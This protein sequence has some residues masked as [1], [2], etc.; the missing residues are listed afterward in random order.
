VTGLRET[1]RAWIVMILIIL[2]WGYAWIAAKIALRYA[3]ALDAA[4]VRLVFGTLFLFAFL[5]WSKASLRP[6]H[7]KW[8]IV[9]GLLQTAGLTMSNNLALLRGEPGGISMLTFTMP[10]WV[11]LFAWPALGERIRGWQW[12]AVFM[13]LA[14]LVL[15]LQPWS[16]QASL[17][18]KIIAVF[19]GICWAVGVICAKYLQSRE[20]VDIINFT[21]WQTVFGTI[22]VVLAERIFDTSAIEWN[23]T[24]LVCA[25]IIGVGA[26]G[27]GWVMWLYVLHRLP[28]GTTS[29][30]SLG[31]PVVAG[32]S[33]WLQL[34]ERPGPLEL[35]GMVLIATALALIS[36]LNIRQSRVSPAVAIE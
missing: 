18:G 29:L 27:L 23:A 5:V 8:L 16:L 31:V 34:G 30:S 9:I 22:P 26:T 10:F 24:F 20:R 36:W 33:S 4:V 35:A 6:K 15:I 13:A 14:G 7:W 2:L 25:L 11:A 21:F 1:Q 28:A 19:G 32:I 12:L 17:V 3:G